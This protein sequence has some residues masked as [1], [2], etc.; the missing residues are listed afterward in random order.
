[1]VWYTVWWGVAWYG[2]VWND[3]IW[4]GM[5]WCGGVGCGMCGGWL[6]C[7]VPSLVTASGFTLEEGVL[8]RT[9]LLFRNVFCC[10]PNVENGIALLFSNT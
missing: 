5:I 2:M 3:M 10:L 6:G 7:G 1:M 8:I 4:Y 9:V